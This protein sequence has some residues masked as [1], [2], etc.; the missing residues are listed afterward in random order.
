MWKM[1]LGCTSEMCFWHRYRQGYQKIR[2]NQVYEGWHRI[3]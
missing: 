2:G 1:I 3:Q